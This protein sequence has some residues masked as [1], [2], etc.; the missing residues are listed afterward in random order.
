MV[1]DLRSAHGEG[2]DKSKR[3]LWD[4]FSRGRRR[5]P[6]SPRRVTL[7]QSLLGCGPKRQIASEDS[8]RCALYVANDI[9][10]PGLMR[11]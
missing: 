11:R 6:G 3:R 10:G 4:G 7:I 1:G 8:V 5:S 2:T 9:L